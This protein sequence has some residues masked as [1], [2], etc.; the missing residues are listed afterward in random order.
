[1]DVHAWWPNFTAIPVEYAE[2]YYPV[3]IEHLR[4]RPDSGGAGLHRGG[5]GLEK[6]YVFLAKGEVS[7]HDDRSRF[8]PWGIGGG[9]AAEGSRKVLIR[10][11]GEEVE[12][13]SKLDFLQVEPGDKLL[14]LTA[15]GGGWGD[16]LQRD[17]E[18][19]RRDVAR[20]FVTPERARASYGVVVDV[21]TGLVDEGTTRALREEQL[22]AR[23]PELPVFDFGPERTTAEADRVGR[24]E[25]VPLA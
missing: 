7:I 10:R 23:P 13:P 9:Q 16:P 4:G 25:A 3:R 19:V 21:E 8:R 2:N 1:M 24:D 14:Y 5:N 22:A 6:L 12:L 11:D 15:G 20:G 18:L 17:P